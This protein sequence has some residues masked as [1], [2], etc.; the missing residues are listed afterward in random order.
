MKATKRIISLVLA[1][2]ICL[3]VMFSLELNAFATDTATQEVTQTVVETETET[4]EA[5][6]NLTPTVEVTEE[7]TEI[8]TQAPTVKPTVKPTEKPSNKEPV[9]DN[10]KVGKVK[11]LYKD[12]KYTN[13]ISFYWNPVNG[14]QGYRVYYMNKDK[15]KDYKFLVATTSTKITVRDLSHTTPYQ[16]KVTAYAVVD[17]VLYEGDACVGKTATQPA[18]MSKPSLKKSSPT[19][20]ISWSRNSRAD[21]YR[22]Y[23]QDSSTKGKLVLYKTIKKNTT[24]TFEDKKVKRGNA[25]NYQVRAYREM[26]SGKIY[27]GEGST[28]RT[29]A[30]LSKPK[31]NKCTSQLR[32][33]TID[34]NNNSVASGFDVYYKADDRSAYK[35][36]KTTKNSYINTTQ[37]RAGHKYSFKI[38]PFRYVGAKKVKVYGSTLGLTKKVTATAYGKNPG[39]TY[40]EISITNQHMWYYVNGK[41][42]VSTPV[43]TGNQGYYSTPKGFFNI[44]QRSSPATLT[45]P[46]WNVNVNYWMAFTYS[47]CGIHDSTWRSSSE[48][49]GTTYKG[50]GSHGCVNTPY[51]KVKKIYQKAKMGTPVIVY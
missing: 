30:G 49:G 40:I 44:W 3:S 51:S 41:C 5:D 7:A 2:I 36:L 24:T 50:N 9:F 43:V 32:R 27:M 31:L 20:A 10:T 12:S 1:L 19:I 25:Y 8:E 48:Y 35:L 21:G 33:V 6:E 16:F 29:V 47:G 42:Y 28:L 15:H 13:K 11:K 39:K 34:W 4:Q 46:T 37:L 23:R 45:G 26:Y 17:G 22:I 14:A 18:T 38:R